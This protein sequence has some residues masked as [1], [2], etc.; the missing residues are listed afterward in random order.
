MLKTILIGLDGS[1]YSETALEMALDWGRRFDAMLVGLGIID[2]PAIARPQPLPPGAVSVAAF[3]QK[4]VLADARRK[5]EAF[6][7]RFSV[8]CA[9]AG[10]ACKVLEDAGLPWEEIVRESQRYD[11][12]LLG[13]RTYFRLNTDE[14]V[15]NTLQQVLRYGSRPVVT[16][17]EVLGG[18]GV[19]VAYD[20]GVAA[21]RAVQTLQ[22]TGLDEGEEVHV[23]T[24]DRD[25]TAAAT[26]AGRAAE[27]LGYHGIK[28]AADPVAAEGSPADLLLQEVRRL[29]PRLLVMGAYGHSRLREIVFGSTTRA[30]LKASPVPLLL[31]H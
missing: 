11:L 26:C 20:G 14:G 1:P 17:P 4:S 8:R 16:A 3:S 25:F 7:G 18:R 19:L 28:A 30:L 13:K 21:A 24:I 12:V 15:D 10:V 27:F 23:V 9:K 6:L 2:E 22:A 5:V 31:Y 29:S